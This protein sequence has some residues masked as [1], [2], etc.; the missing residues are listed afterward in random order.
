MRQ[1][2][3]MRLT[4][5]YPVGTWDTLLGVKRSDREAD[6]TSLSTAQL[7]NAWSYT[8]STSHTFMAGLHNIR[9]LELT[10]TTL[11]TVGNNIYF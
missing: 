3:T 8:T 7:K 4:I 9:P 5:S 11:T 10:G 6:H 2:S 1:E